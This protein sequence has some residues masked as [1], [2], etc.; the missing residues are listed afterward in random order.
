MVGLIGNSQPNDGE[1]N[2]IRERYARRKN[3]DSRY[4][5][6]TPGHLFLVQSREK[7][8][9]ELLAR[10]GCLPISDEEDP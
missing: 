2:R 9:L 1:E 5:W 10:S 4:S 6:F 3:A 7:R 8:V